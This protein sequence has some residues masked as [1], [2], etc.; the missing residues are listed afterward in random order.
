MKKRFTPP[1]LVLLAVLILFSVVSCKDNPAEAPHE[2]TWDTGTV[3][4]EPTCTDEGVKTYKCTGCSETK[5]EPV[6]ATGHKW[7]GGSVT[8]APTCT[9]EGVRTYKCTGCSET[10]TEPVPATG[11]TWNEGSVTTEPTCTAD[12]VKTYNCTECSET[13]TEPIPKLSHSFNETGECTVCGCYK[14]GDNLLAIYDSGEKTLRITGS[15]DMTAYTWND[16]NKNSSAPWAGKYK[17][18]AKKVIID[19]GVTSI[20]EHAFSG[21]E[22]VTE[23]VIG[24]DVK[25][26]NEKAF[27]KCSLLNTV[28]FSVGSA[29][30]TIGE[31]SFSECKNLTTISLPEGLVKIG[32]YAFNGTKIDV[33]DIPSSL[34]FSNIGSFWVPK[35]LNAINVAS[36]NTSAKSVQGVVYSI[37][38]KT[39]LCVPPAKTSYT[40]PSD[41][42]TIGKEAFWNW[43]G[44]TITIPHSVK[45]IGKDAFS[46][47]TV[48][49]VT[50]ENGVETLGELAF[51]YTKVQSIVLP[52]SLKSI[53]INAFVTC[54]S[55]KSVEIKSSQVNKIDNN[56]FG[57]CTA[58]TAIKI[59]MTQTAGS[60]LDK[61][62]NKWGASSAT[63]TWSDTVSTT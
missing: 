20:S 22:N 63:V 61:Q 60:K 10:K 35:T 53:G 54:S 48:S 46:W 32:G 1:V 39:V 47:S 42:E 58:L 26:I 29:L 57:D 23:V 21:M 45:T 55:L 37:D 2:H 50:F 11:H 28:S 30:E 38:G 6:P 3:T 59:N 17:S 49:S 33:I 8:T 31:K 19:D 25:S 16:T 34:D 56:A 13:K 27:Y 51:A 18:H 7:D 14:A 12:G 9:E 24:K 44:T 40:I 62:N 36:G 41:V 15:G 4:T 5:T 52:E 43:T